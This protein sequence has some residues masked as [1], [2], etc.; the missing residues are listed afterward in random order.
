MLSALMPLL[1]AAHSLISNPSDFSSA[2]SWDKTY[3]ANNAAT[4]EWLLPYEGRLREGLLK[5]LEGVPRRAPILELGSGT[6]LL[7]TRLC[8]EGFESVTASDASATAMRAARERHGAALPGLKF[9]VCDARDTRLAAEAY[10]AVVDKGT[11]DALCT[12]D[13]FDYEAGRIA[14][15]V[16]RLLVPGGVW[17]SVSLMPPEVV[18]PHLSRPVVWSSL[19]STELAVG[20]DT[21]VYL[22]TAAR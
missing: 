21:N 1:A 17:A 4:V 19:E 3:A 13:G 11:L 10:G 2:F 15:E 12:G 22:H 18:L 14:A 5:A 16:F 6:S 8:H 7:A 9:V 20:G